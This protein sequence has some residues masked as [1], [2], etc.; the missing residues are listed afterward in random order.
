MPRKT[1]T[2]P[3]TRNDEIILDVVRKSKSIELRIESPGGERSSIR[4]SCRAFAYSVS[5]AL[6][7]EFEKELHE[8]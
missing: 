4:I 6:R 1:D 2:P 7:V 8:L 3:L 5:N